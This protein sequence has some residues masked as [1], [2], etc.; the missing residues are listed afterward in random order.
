MRALGIFRSRRGEQHPRTATVR[1]SLVAM[2]GGTAKTDP[3][4]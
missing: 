2:D 3:S 1:R 4:S